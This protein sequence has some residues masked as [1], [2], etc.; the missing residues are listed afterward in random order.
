M[1]PEIAATIAAIVPHGAS[2]NPCL[3]H[4]RCQQRVELR[5][6][7]RAHRRR[8]GS[9]AAV[10]APYRGWLARVRACES[11]GNYAINTGNGFYGAYQFTLPSWY[12]VGGRGMP[13]WAPPIEQDYR[14]VLLLHSQGRGAWPVCG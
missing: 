3:E 4:P 12:S 6:K 13:H 10:I 14:A 8:V 9:W 7:R 11:G 5:W 2:E 1:I